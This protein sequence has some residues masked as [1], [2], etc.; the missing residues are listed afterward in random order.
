[1]I[2]VGDFDGDADLDFANGAIWEDTDGF[3][4]VVYNSPRGHLVYDDR[5]WP[6]LTENHFGL[7]PRPGTIQGTVF[8]DRNSDG[9]QSIREPGVL[10][11]TVGTSPQLLVYLDGDNSGEYDIG[12]AT[13]QTDSEGNFSFAGLAPLVP[14]ALASKGSRRLASNATRAGK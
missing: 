4:E 1:M 9:E 13:A 3:T 14:I 6:S 2:R 12:E 11:W 7:Q 8:D 10:S 5:F